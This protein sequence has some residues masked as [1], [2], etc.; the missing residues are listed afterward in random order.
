M[1][2]MFPSGRYSPSCC[3]D[4]ACLRAVV[5]FKPPPQ[6]RHVGSINLLQLATSFL[7]IFSAVVERERAS[8]RALAH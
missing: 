8:L 5:L 7:G 6:H 2:S 1:S 3:Q 4:P